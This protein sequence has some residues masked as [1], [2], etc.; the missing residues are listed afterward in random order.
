MKDLKDLLTKEFPEAKVDLSEPSD[1]DG[2]WFLDLS[3]QE[4]RAIIQARRQGNSI[5]YGV[6]TFTQEE[7]EEVSYGDNSS[8][9]ETDNLDRALGYISGAHRILK[10]QAFR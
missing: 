6:S 4:M 7:W 3:F 10:Q 5:K 9:M 2:I 1:P 8:H